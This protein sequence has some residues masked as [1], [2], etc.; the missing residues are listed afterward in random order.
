MNNT[1]RL[2]PKEKLKAKIN[3][4]LCIIAAILF[5]TVL[6]MVGSET[7]LYRIIG[8]SMNPTLYEKNLVLTKG[9]K[10]YER[11]DIIAFKKDGSTTIKRLIGLPGDEI[12]IDFDGN[13]YVNGEVLNEPYVMFHQMHPIEIEFPLTVP[14]GKYFVLGDNRA[15][16]RDSRE[17][18]FGFV[19]KASVI[20]KVIRSLIPYKEIK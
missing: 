8:H 10:E 7:R 5:G 18:S 15:N 3:L 13:V 9:Q 20:G 2:S 4:I 16:S 11:G 19:D 17:K 14:E 1:V 12:I 6:I